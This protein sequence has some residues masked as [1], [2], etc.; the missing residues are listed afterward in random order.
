M[1]KNYSRRDFMGL[2]SSGVIG[3][4]FTGCLGGIGNKK[5]PNIIIIFCDDQGYADD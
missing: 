2:I 3:S 4:V 1:N 5:K